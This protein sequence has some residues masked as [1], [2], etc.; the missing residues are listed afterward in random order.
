MLRSHL[1]YH[2]STLVGIQVWWLQYTAANSLCQLKLEIHKLFCEHF[3]VR[4]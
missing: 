4:H 2:S 3:N 1:F